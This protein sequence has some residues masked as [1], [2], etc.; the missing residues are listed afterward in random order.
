MPLVGQLLL[1]IRPPAAAGRTIPPYLQA[2]CLV[3]LQGLSQVSVLAVVYQVL[4]MCHLHMCGWK[5]HELSV[6][7]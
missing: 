4:Y 5:L 2:P 3:R 7:C 6:A 1:A